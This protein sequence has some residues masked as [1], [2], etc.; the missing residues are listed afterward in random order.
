MAVNNWPVTVAEIDASLTIPPLDIYNEQ[1]HKKVFELLKGLRF[2]GE[3]ILRVGAIFQDEIEKGIK[4]EPSSLQMENTYVPELPDGTEEGLFLALDV[5]GTNFR[6]LLLELHE[7]K[8]IRE[9]VKHYHIA[10]ELRLGCGLKLFDFLASCIADFVKVFN[11]AD[12]TL[13]L[14]FTFSFPMHQRSLDIGLLVTWT[15]SFK[16]SGVQGEDVVKM[17]RDAIH[18]R[19][20]NHVEVVAVLNDTTGTLLQGASLDHRT[21][22]GLILGTGSNACYLERA[23]RVHHW[24]S[25]RH[26]EKEIVIDIEWG[27]FGDNG[28]IDFI[29]TDYDYEVD[30]NSLIKRSFTF[31]K[32]IGGKYLGE[33]VRVILVRLIKEELLFDGD[34]PPKL[35]VHGSFTTSYVSLI[36]QDCIDN[37]TMHTETI[38]SEDFDVEFSSSDDL[39]I[40]KHVCETVSLRAA[41]L[42]SIG[43]AAIL[44]HMDR[45]DNTVAV[46]GSLYKHHPRIHKWMNKFI[47]LLVPNHTFRLMLAEDGSGKGAGLTAAIAMKLKERF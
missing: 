27:A 40:V 33:V 7:G 4:D 3:K 13:P 14:G 42:V 45:P 25:E 44:Q 38:L 32:Y 1:K 46:D 2:S 9:E 24:E 20:D 36:E 10:D 41:L 11:V 47:S 29:K 16:C 23:D 5:G 28:V 12:K 8:L 43:I 6:V 19:G 30:D 26:G 34:A 22:I 39:A 35:L 31:E 37:S 15:K 17:L 18:R 21:T